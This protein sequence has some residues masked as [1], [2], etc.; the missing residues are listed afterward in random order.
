[1]VREQT[2]DRSTCHCHIGKLVESHYYFNDDRRTVRQAG[3]DNE[4]RTLTRRKRAGEERE[5]ER[6]S[7]RG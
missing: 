4:T 1:M 3:S 7:L 6:E 5:T 2:A